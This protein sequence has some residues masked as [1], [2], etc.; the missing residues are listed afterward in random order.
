MI[1]AQIMLLEIAER[2]L[3]PDITLVEMTGTLALG[4]ESQRIES[5]IDD[6]VK[7]GSLRVIIDISGVGYLD[8]AG[9]GLLALAAGKLKES[10]AKFALVAPGGGRVRQLL[11]LT[12]MTTIWN[13][14]PTIEAAKQS[15]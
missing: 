5:L 4:R 12:Q 1:S 2:E 11:S 15:L 14:C 8:S 7:R 6:L 9:I 13:V 3:E 10:G